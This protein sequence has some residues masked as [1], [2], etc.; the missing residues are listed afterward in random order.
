MQDLQ[1]IKRKIDSAEDLLSVASTMKSMAAVNVRQYEEAVSSLVD[2]RQTVE[3]GLQVVLRQSPGLLESAAESERRNAGIV[4]FGSDHGMCGSF[5]ERIRDFTLRWIGA[6]D[7]PLD[8]LV[9][10]TV[11]HRI[12]V[13]LDEEQ[14]AL[15]THLDVPASVDG[16]T[17]F[18]D[19]VLLALDDWRQRQAVDHIWLLFNQTT[20]P[21]TFT[22]TDNALLPIDRPWL[23]HIDR[24]QWPSRVLPTTRMP[25]EELFSS[26]IREHL[27]ITIFRACCESLAAENAA[28]LNSMQSAERNIEERLEELTADYRRT[29]QSAITAELLDIVSG[30]EALMG[31]DEDEPT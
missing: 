5:N 24:R 20:G 10:M 9:A 12:A 29:R 19:D 22:P 23:E 11:G 3:L 31:E 1:N 26:L 4:V 17:S 27:F 18:V 8:S 6:R 7:I 15:D 14:I 13:Q 2:Y 16:V 30:Y 21:S 25:P 28:R